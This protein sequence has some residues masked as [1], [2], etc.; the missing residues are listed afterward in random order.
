MGQRS[1]RQGSAGAVLAAAG[2]LDM[3]VRPGGCP[4]PYG[5]RPRY[6]SGRFQAGF[7]AFASLRFG[8]KRLFRDLL[9]AA[10]SKVARPPLAV[11]RLVALVSVSAAAGP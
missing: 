5:R 10:A 3:K 6:S 11:R 7:F 9:I 2:E 1:R 8:A 4:Q